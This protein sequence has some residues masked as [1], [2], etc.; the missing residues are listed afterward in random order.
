LKIKTLVRQWQDAQLNCTPKRE[1]QLADEIM[2]RVNQD[3]E[4]I[5][6]TPRDPKFEWRFEELYEALKP[7]AHYLLRL[8]LMEKAG[9]H[10]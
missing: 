3:L 6:Q 7:M 8:Q 5:K 1:A 4:E 9:I 2:G 10:P